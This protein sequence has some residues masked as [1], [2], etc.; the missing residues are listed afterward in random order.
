ML[1]ISTVFTASSPINYLLCLSIRSNSSSTQVLSWDWSNSVPSL[2]STS[3][4]VCVCVCV[5]VC[6]SCSA[7]SNSVT[8]WTIARQA[9]LSMEFSSQE[10]CSGLPCPSPGD[11]PNLGTEPRSPALAGRFFTVWATSTSSS[12]AISTT[13][14]ITFSTEVLNPS[15]S[16]MRVG[17]NFFQTSVN[18]GI[19]TSSHRDRGPW[20]AAVYGVAQSRTRLKWLSSSSSRMMNPFQW[21]STD[22]A[23]VHQRNHYL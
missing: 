21:F 23:Q 7:K 18:A 1:V 14:A 13:S 3:A 10:Y 11:L 12:F 15:K 2:D 16:P 22:F 5:C 4:S 19:L 9:P 17:I 8:P 20:W 6:I